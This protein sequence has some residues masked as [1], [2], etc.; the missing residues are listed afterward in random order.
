VFGEA[1][2]A[3]MAARGCHLSLEESQQFARSLIRLFELGALTFDPPMGGVDDED[4]AAQT[5][6]TTPSMKPSSYET[7]LL[8]ASCWTRRDTAP[9][10][11]EALA[12]APV[13]NT[14][15]RKNVCHA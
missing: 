8:A 15:V 4:G 1:I 14:V 7:I 5:T 9:V 12:V 2:Q 6:V 13:T 3:A 10:T 11:S